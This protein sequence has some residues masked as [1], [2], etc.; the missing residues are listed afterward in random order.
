MTILKKQK[1]IKIELVKATNTELD[2]EKVNNMA[3]H[4]N[5][6]LLQAFPGRF[7]R[8]GKFVITDGNHRLA[9]LKLIG[10]EYAP[11]VELTHD[12]WVRVA[13]NKESIEFLV[14]RG[15]TLLTP[16]EICEK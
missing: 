9:A 3:S 14:E 5:T 13:I 6:T 16:P 7:D 15:Y 2:Q 8:E 11:V 10:A 1:L 4:L 12:E